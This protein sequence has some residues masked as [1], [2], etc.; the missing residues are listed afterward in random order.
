MTRISQSACAALL[1]AGTARATFAAEAAQT[2][3]EKLHDFGLAP[4]NVGAP[5][6]GRILVVFALIVALAWAATWLLRRYGA[7]FRAGTLGT[8]SPIRQLARNTLPGGIACHVVEAQGQRVLITVT[9]HGVAS[10]LLGD[11]PAKQ[12]APEKES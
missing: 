1:A 4:A 11:V 9:R 2:G 6:Y 10:L 7:R 12:S 3:A 8:T 5:G